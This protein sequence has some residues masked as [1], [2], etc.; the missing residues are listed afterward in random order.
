MA[1]HKRSIWIVLLA[2]PLIMFVFFLGWAMYAA[3]H[4]QEEA[5]TVER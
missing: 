5:P 1:K 3:N 4:K 2:L